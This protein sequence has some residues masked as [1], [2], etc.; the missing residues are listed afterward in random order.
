MIV[1]LSAT[2]FLSLS[3]PATAQ[4][5]VLEAV[6]KD[7]QAK[8]ISYNEREVTQVDYLSKR[9]RLVTVADLSA[10]EQDRLVLA[11]FPGEEPVGLIKRVFRDGPN[12]GTKVWE[13][14]IDLS[15]IDPDHNYFSEE[16]LKKIQKLGMTPDAFL[17]AMLKVRLFIAYWDIELSSGN[18]VLSY[19]PMT[20]GFIGGTEIGP[21]QPQFDRRAFV[22]IDGDLDLRL[23]GR[24]QYR[25]DSL[26]YSP[27]YHAVYEIDPENSVSNG[28]DEEYLDSLPPKQRRP[29]RGD[30]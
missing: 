20:G 14:E 4:P 16:S 28:G 13:G 25:I 12:P 15:H 11:L 2:L 9:F 23:I 27:R 17:S 5:D 24:G 3:L 21:D 18:A 6:G 19:P 10:F 29:I 8:V 30:L 1:R 7:L 22:S 26:E